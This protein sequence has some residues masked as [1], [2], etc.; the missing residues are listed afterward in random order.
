MQSSSVT[1]AAESSSINSIFL[2]ECLHMFFVRFIPTF[3]VLHRATFIFRDCIHPLLLNAIAIGSL[4][5]G[6]KEAVAKGEVLWRL[7]HTAVATSWQTLITHKGPYDTCQGVQLVITALLGQVYGSLS[8][9][10]AIRTM[11][12]AFHAQGFTWANY[13]GMFDAEPYSTDDLPFNNATKTE[14]EYQWRVW[15]AREIQHRALLAHYMLDGLIA[16]MSGK[17]TSVRHASNQLRLPSSEAAF[18]AGTAEEWL[19][20]MH[21]QPAS[22]ATFRNLFRLFFSPVDDHHWLGQSLSGFSLRVVLEGLQ[23]LLSDCDEDGEAA[24]GVPSKTEICRALARIYDNITPNMSLYS[25]DRLETLL[26]WHAICLDAVIDS[27][28]LCRHV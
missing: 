25:V 15:V 13:C 3:P 19:N 22:K 23:S 21:A 26:R 8:K 27:S 20:L 14:K 1:A 24:V 9:N 28:V 16:Q 18:A 17:A 12:Q 7:A 11:S 2:D 10:R 6:P 4:Y 5:L